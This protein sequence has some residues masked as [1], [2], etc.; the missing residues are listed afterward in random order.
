[1]NALVSTIVIFLDGER[2]LR[3]AIESV[4]AQSHREWELLLVDDGST[5]GST[6]IARE[7]AERFPD[8]VRYLEHEGH[9]N[10]GMSASR[11]LGA[12]HARG[13]YVAFLDADDVWE[14]EK[15][16][17]QVAIMER[18]PEAA[19]VYGRTLIWHGWTGDADDERNDH[20]YDL[21][22]VPDTLVRPPELLLLL[23]ENR[24]QTPT[25]CNALVRR[26]VYEAVGGFEESFRG[27]YEDQA[28]FT[29]VHLRWPVYVAS[30]RWARYRQHP[31]SHSSAAARARRYHA[32][33]LRF[34]EWVSGYFDG[35]GVRDKRVLGALKRQMRA[36]RYPKLYEAI[37]HVAQLGRQAAVR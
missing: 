2:F 24:C 25:T 13:A 36:C 28:F 34:L 11:N 15:L 26:E 6:A 12:R 22:V 14:P 7:Y 33:R 32:N 20:V 1:M 29:K 4:F 19:M 30:A 16:S 27:L 3:D 18:E 10:R 8:R 31:E 17:E 21:G 23:L 37:S 5:D 35:Q 9:A